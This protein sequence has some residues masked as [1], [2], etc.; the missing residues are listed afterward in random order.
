MLTML[1]YSSTLIQSPDEWPEVLEQISTHAHH[2]NA[3]LGV[4]GVLL[5]SR[6]RC[7]QVLE[8]FPEKLMPLYAQI[9]QDQRHTDVQTLIETNIQE[10]S[11][12]A[13]YMR[14][15]DMSDAPPHA[16]SQIQRLT[17]AYTASMKPKAAD[18]IQILLTLIA[19]QG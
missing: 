15:I 11:F 3:K 14:V 8:G 1:A 5:F 13:W 4:T 16:Q 12:D 17:D 18:F 7:I 19:S 10:R 2:K 9:K 6:G